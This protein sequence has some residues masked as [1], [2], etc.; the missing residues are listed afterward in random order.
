MARHRPF[1]DGAGFTRHCWECGHARGW[2]KGHFSGA[3]IARC[4][5]TGLFVEKCDSPN[6]R[7]SHLGPECEYEYGGGKA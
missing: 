3:D 7:C 4:E 6:N 1:T 5:L 2:R